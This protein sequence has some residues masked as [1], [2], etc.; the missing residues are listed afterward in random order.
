MK[1]LVAMV[2]ALLM[3]QLAAAYPQLTVSIDAP[4]YAEALGPSLSI[5]EVRSFIGGTAT[6]LVKFG[7]ENAYFKIEGSTVTYIPNA[8]G[9]TDFTL[10]GS[11]DAWL[12]LLNAV[13]KP[14]TFK[15]LLAARAI[16]ISANDGI[17]QAA[18][19][20]ALAGG[21]LNVDPIKDGDVLRYDGDGMV[22]MVNNRPVLKV[23]NDQ[24]LLNRFGGVVGGLPR[25]YDRFSAPPAFTGLYFA[26]PPGVLAQFPGLVYDTT[27]RSPN[28]VGPWNIFK[29][30]P[31]LIGPNDILRLNPGLIGPADMAILNPNLHGPAEFAH[32]MG[33]GAHSRSVQSLQD[34]GMISNR[35]DLSSRNRWGN[36]R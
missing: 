19:N 12:T 5:P 17:K 1:F 2:G 3:L 6:L 31:G 10:A 32:M 36:R 28:A 22:R 33:I 8:Y 7:S 35:F 9:T 26:K 23:G 29:I 18:I 16:V 27:S 13:D 14:L 11:T 34:R 4:R 24:F 25:N 30:N 20:A 21:A 15:R